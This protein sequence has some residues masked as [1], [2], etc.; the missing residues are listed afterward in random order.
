MQKS[1]SENKAHAIRSCCTWWFMVDA[2][3][4]Q[5]YALLA[6][7]K[8]NSQKRKQESGELNMAAH[9]HGLIYARRSYSMYAP[10]G[11]R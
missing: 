10:Q 11:R 7:S 1:A 3:S 5:N 4:G 2:Q 9:V 8:D 6:V